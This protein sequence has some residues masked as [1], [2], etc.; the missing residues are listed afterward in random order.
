MRMRKGLCLFALLMM[1]L[2]LNYSCSEAAE[3]RI[4]IIVKTNKG[5]PCLKWD[6]VKGADGYEVRVCE[7]K[8]VQIT[9]VK[10]SAK[11]VMQ[12]SQLP[13]GCE[14]T[15]LTIALNYHGFPVKK[16]TIVDKYLPIKKKGYGNIETTFLG[17]PYGRG[18]RIFTPGLVTTANRFLKEKD[19]ELR[20]Y[21]ISGTK[22]TEICDYVADGKPVCVWA[23]CN[24]YR[25]PTA[26]I[27]WIYKDKKYTFSRSEHCMT[28]IGFDLKKNTIIVANPLTGIS[29]Y[30][31]SLFASRY[32]DIGKRAMVIR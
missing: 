20:A 15:A 31:R 23:T 26:L 5:V 13:T 19:T 25:K 7:K 14:A 17:N 24:M 21:D 32:T 3:E 12:M 30:S 22:L 2:F 29:T 1:G 6:K 9:K 18:M 10:L 27:H 8:C 11:C 28:V 16:T 4:T